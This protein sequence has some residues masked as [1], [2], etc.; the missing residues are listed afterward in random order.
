MSEKDISRAVKLIAELSIDRAS[1]VFSKTIRSGAKIEFDKAYIADISNLTENAYSS[2]REVVCA[3]VDL[4]G[5]YSFRFIFYID[6]KDSLKLA[7]L[8]L[9]KEIGTTKE[10]NI[11]AE[12]AVQE[13]GNILASTVANVF[14]AHINV[15]LK[16]MPPIVVRDFLG[17][18]FQEYLIEALGDRDEILTIET[19]FHLVK[20]D[21]RCAMFLIPYPGS[22][23]IFEIMDG[24]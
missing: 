2:D 17:A 22:E 18:I 3:F 24:S 8:I 10:Y 9:R 14:A 11:Y 23:K 21:I 1:Q 20:T 19:K 15:S 12:S 4:K 5:E 7:D 16:P 6:D 13:I